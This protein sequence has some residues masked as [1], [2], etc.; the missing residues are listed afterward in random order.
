VL[1]EL[2]AREP[3][4]HHPEFGASRQDFEDMT[5]PGF[6]EVGASGRCYS[7]RYII[8]TLVERYANPHEDV[9]EA[10]GFHCRELAPN[11]YLLTYRLV[12]DG[13]RVTR[14]ST[15]WRKDQ[16]QWKI[17]YHQGTIVGSEA[18]DHET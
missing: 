12:Q 11:V 2:V 6:W 3:I 15:I 4:F 13:V 5:D 9:W 7:R 16:D 14:R 8:D 1:G 17:V 18:E 10:G